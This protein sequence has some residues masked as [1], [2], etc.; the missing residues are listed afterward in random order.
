MV[1]DY[2][3]ANVHRVVTVTL[4]LLVQSCDAHYMAA[5]CTHAHCMV[6]LCDV[7]DLAGLGQWNGRQLYRQDV[8]T[9]QHYISYCLNVATK[10]SVGNQKMHKVITIHV[11]PYMLVASLLT[12][13]LVIICNDRMYSKSY[14]YFYGWLL[15]QS[16][17]GHGWTIYFNWCSSWNASYIAIALYR[18]LAIQLVSCDHVMKSLI[19]M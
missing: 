6:T 4:E 3:V 5:N 2:Q 7:T 15:Y 17:H 14:S 13:M 11:Q 10:N 8:H 18:E 1:F 12:C 19:S 9:I 16:N